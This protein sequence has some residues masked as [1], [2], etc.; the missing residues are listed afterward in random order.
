MSKESEESEESEEESEEEHRNVTWAIVAFT[1]QHQPSATA[2]RANGAVLA[3]RVRRQFQRVAPSP[4]RATLAT[5]AEGALPQLIVV[6]AL[7]ALFAFVDAL[8]VLVLAEPTILAIR[9]F[10]VAFHLIGRIGRI[11]VKDPKTS[12]F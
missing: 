1:G 4:T 7:R 5:D 3:L 10:V 9:G 11:V 8:F 6:L 12:I 2:V